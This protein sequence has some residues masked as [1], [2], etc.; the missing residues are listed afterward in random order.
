MAAPRN[1]RGPSALSTTTPAPPSRPVITLTTDFGTNGVFVGVMKGVILRTARDA[2][3]V[4]LTHAVPPQHVVAGALALWS[5]AAWFPPGTIHIAIVDPGVGSRRRALLVETADAYFIGPDNGLLS[6]A[7]PARAVRRVFDIS[8]S[9]ARLDPVSRTFHGR[10]VFAPVAAALA[11]GAAPHTLGRPVRTIERLRIPRV[12]R[13][14]T[15]LRGEVL[16]IDGF[17]NLVTNVST[18]DLASAGF[19]GRILSITIGPHVVPFRTS[20]ASAPSG[21]P[22]AV[23]NSSNLLEIAV[24]RGSAATHLESGPGTRVAVE[25]A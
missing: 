12:R 18:V 22:V 25:V 10:D 7:A 8:R 20:Y 1:K 24:N 21:S 14:G 3:L 17:G 19:R 13:K 15:T 11:A 9:R 4:D 16:W 6:L 2:H 5:A 23:V